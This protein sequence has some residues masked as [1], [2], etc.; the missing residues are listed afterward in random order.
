MMIATAKRRRLLILGG[1]IEGRLLAERLV[2]DARFN[3]IV[4]LAGRTE[5]PLPIPGTI[6]RGGF[7]GVEGLKRY[8]H[9]AGIDLLIDATHPFASRIKASAIRASAETG[10]PLIC[11]R[12]EP[13]SQ[14][15]GDRWQCVGSSA[16]AVEALGQTPRCVFL[17]LGR[18]D[19]GA[20][21]EAPHHLYLI[22]SVDA[23]EPQ[24]DLPNA[25]YIESRGPFNFTDEIEIMRNYGIDVL[26]SKN[27]GGDS[28]YAKIEAARKLG[29]EAI[30]IRRPEPPVTLDAPPTVS[31][32][33]A[34]MQLLTHHLAV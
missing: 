30:M 34:A 23:L 21:E 25:H 15:P 4:S 5:Q 19:I 7:G 31:S 33:D 9:S 29:I 32:V 11:V 26:V 12:R 8:M 16:E 1:T 24:P 13:W 14:Q 18:N 20:F 6:R 27:S 17:T 10:I 28:T 22:R 2:H 3:L